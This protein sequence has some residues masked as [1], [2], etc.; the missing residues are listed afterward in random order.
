MDL[1]TIAEPPVEEHVVGGG[2]CGTKQA[3]GSESL[4]ADPWIQ[5]CIFLRHGNIWRGG[6]I[7]YVALY[8]KRCCYL[9]AFGT[10]QSTGSVSKS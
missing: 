4:R 6:N 10:F 3:L 9:E 2:A 1:L 5:F 7:T 8:F